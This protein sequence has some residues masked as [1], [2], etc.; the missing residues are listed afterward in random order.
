VD[1]FTHWPVSRNLDALPVRS[2]PARVLQ[3][4]LMETYA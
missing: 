3:K 1:T 4:E 2:P